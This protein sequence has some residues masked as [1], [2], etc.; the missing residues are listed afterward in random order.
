MAL[1]FYLLFAFYL[2]V[3]PFT[4][5]FA[6]KEELRDSHTAT[7]MASQLSSDVEAYK[8]FL[9]YCATRPTWRESV[10]SATL[11]SLLFLLISVILLWRATPDYHDVIA[12]LTIFVFLITFIVVKAS[13]DFFMYHIMNVSNLVWWN[14]L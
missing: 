10:I 5:F 14:N 13:R 6:L 4:L 9:A 1:S 11:S 8:T 7:E 12:I 3:I 2:F